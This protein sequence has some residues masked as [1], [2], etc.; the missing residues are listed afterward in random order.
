MVEEN[1]EVAALVQQINEF[2]ESR[3]TGVNI[4]RVDLHDAAMKPYAVVF[5][6][7]PVANY[8]RG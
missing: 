2:K 4:K 6:S 5:G 1:N 8:L 7:E 3:A